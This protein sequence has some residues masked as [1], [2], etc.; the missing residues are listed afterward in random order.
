MTLTPSQVLGEGILGLQG[1]SRKGKMT[2]GFAIGPV[3]GAK[4]YETSNGF[5][6]FT[7]WA[8]RMGVHYLDRKA[9]ELLASDFTFCVADGRVIVGGLD[10][11]DDLRSRE[12]ERQVATIAGYQR[13]RWE[14]TKAM[15]NWVNT[16]PAIVIGRHIREVFPRAQ[17]VLE[18]VRSD[19]VIDNLV[20]KR[21]GAGSLNAIAART[22]KDRDN[23][24]IALASVS[25]AFITFDATGLTKPQQAERAIAVALRAGFAKR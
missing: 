4:V 2:I 23:A 11:T 9:C 20:A 15:L 25:D 1:D 7:V 13:V 6:G 24:K 16:R 12:T 5:R 17:L 10:V 21:E 8:Q 3:L 18:V 22:E 19:A 14:Y